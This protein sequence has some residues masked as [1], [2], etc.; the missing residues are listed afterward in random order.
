[1]S[2]RGLASLAVVVAA[3]SLRGGTAEDGSTALA[4]TRSP[5]PKRALLAPMAR[6]RSW[7]L[8]PLTSPWGHGGVPALSA[9][10]MTRGWPSH[11]VTESDA[12]TG[13]GEVTDGTISGTTAKSARGRVRSAVQTTAANHGS[14]D[15]PTVTF[16][17]AGA[18]LAAAGDPQCD[19]MLVEPSPPVVD[20]V[21]FVAVDFGWSATSPPPVERGREA[22]RGGSDSALSTPLMEGPDS[23]GDA[24]TGEWSS[25]PLTPSSQEGDGGRRLTVSP[26]LVAVF[27]CRFAQRPRLPQPC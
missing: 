14:F 9:S 8:L 10:T 24:G 7:C 19:A 22:C 17:Q 2:W 18:S 21:V 20:V 16:R 27:G 1:M 12:T 4:A 3:V 13:T 6:T 11:D 23:D 25:S 26:S 15:H 5:R